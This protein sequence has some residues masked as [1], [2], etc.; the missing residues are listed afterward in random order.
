MC[1]IFGQIGL[2]DGVLSREQLDAAVQSLA[3]RGPD[4]QG[5][6]QGDA[7]SLGVR[8]LSIIDLRHGGQ[9][10][11]NEDGSCVIIHN[12]EIYNYVELRALLEPLGHVFRTA[13]DTEV[14]LHAYEEWGADCLR[15]FNGMFAFAIW[16]RRPRVL[17]LARDRIGEKPLYYYQDAERLVFASEIKAIL[18]DASVPRR[19][20][21]RGLANFLAF[22]H[23]VAPETMFDNIRKV[24]P[25]HYLVVEGKRT[26][27]VEYWNVGAD[28]QL[29]ADATLSE[30]EYA[31][32][33]LSLLRDSVRLRM[34]ADVPVGAFLSGGIDSSAIVALITQHATGPVRTFSLGF[35]EGRAY[36]ELGDAK[37]VAQH[38]GTE[39][40]E[41]EVGPADFERAFS[42][43]VYHY[44]E[45]FGDA[46]GFPLYLISR[47]AREHVKVALA[48]DGSDELFGG[49]RRYVVDGWASVYHRL[50]TQLAQRVIPGGVDL[51]PRLRRVKRAVH[52][53][54]IRDPAERYAA[55]LMY[56][57][58]EMQE[59]LL[60]DDAQAQ[61]SGHNPSSPFHEYY[62]SLRSPCDASHVNR[63]MFI[64]LKTLLVD[65]YMEKMD[66]ATMACGLEARL[67]F[68]DHRMVEL[69]F[70]IPGGLKVGRLSTKRILRHSLSGLLPQR[71]LSKRKHGFAVPLDSWFRDKMKDFAFEILF[72]P[73][74]RRRGYIH[75]C[76]V[77]RLWREHLDGRH[78]WDTHL[79]LLLNLELWHRTYLDTEGS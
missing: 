27:S 37:R 16:D 9:P 23:A 77:E 67:P 69:A 5:V 46:A 59:Q 3:H 47:F 26:E 71:V 39:H 53:L 29:P 74:T 13:S 10:M 63:L 38:F 49:Y 70:Q 78:V 58:P 24:L 52:T 6:W 17:F 7:V 36:N 44:D 54:P 14:V 48:G 76:A 41:L 28:P 19:L 22:G 4:D 2:T 43:L 31:E 11:W 56:F 79:W 60:T 50:P 55:W 66:K 30:D 15:R 65:G 45:P 34:V 51:L 25:G 68:L 18:A 35:R 75:A 1:G 42:T 57:T 40:Y 8:R 33:I 64:D 32:R 12:G 73:R 21:I 72:D 20:N 61:L 62:A